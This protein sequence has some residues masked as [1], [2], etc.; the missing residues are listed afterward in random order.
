MLKI[1]D[2]IV[3]DHD[4]WLIVVAGLI[5][6]L[7]SHTC[8]SLLHRAVQQEP[9]QKMW[10]L[11][12][13][14][15]A[16][17]SGV[18]ATHFIAMLAYR[19]PML[20]G[21]DVP[22]TVLSAAVA[23]GLAAVGL[24]LALNGWYLLGGAISGGMISAMHYTGMAGFTGP[25][26]I[27]WNDGYVAASMLIGIVL[28][29]LA[30]YFLPRAAG[31]KGRVLVVSL[32][33][34]AICGMHFTGMTAAT[35]VFD[36]V[37]S[38]AETTGLERHSLAIVVAAV[39]L[40]LLGAGMASAMLDGYL[41]D[42]NALEAQRLR[43]YVGELEAT[44]SELEATTAS[45][46]RALEAAAASSQAKSQ[47]LATMS[48]ELRTPLNAI[49]GFAEILQSQALGPLGSARYT[50][51]ATDIHD[52]GSHLLSLINDVLDFSKAEAGRLDLR[53][54]LLDLR[55][56][57]G[58][59]LRLV[60]PGAREAGLTVTAELPGEAPKVLADARRLKQ[61]AL[62]LLSNALKF[63]PDGGSVRVSLSF[64]GDGAAISVADDGIGM[65]PQQIPIA[66]EPFGQVDSS[67]SRRHEG[68]G[69]GL[70]LCRRFA[71]AHGGSLSIES[72]LG[73][74][75][76]VTVRLPAG[77]LQMTEAA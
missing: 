7:A 61:I 41:A 20:A 40:L 31:M 74:G 18:W 42:R 19:T 67:L 47:F 10:W 76:V 11:G 64:D 30:F 54:E 35:L 17:G 25:F 77:R 62:N 45:L 38:L 53:E 14:A 59:C 5:C 55:E 57:V 15:V 22:L 36:P 69:L 23:I 52:S 4:V 28:A 46:S 33:T 39:A 1:A 2:C 48:H 70:P 75:T 32:F 29:V 16:M 72:V 37:G 51:Y 44:R 27:S 71:E 43:R 8:F 66:L 73:E 3:E 24:W 26:W 65:T 12:A 9:K 58:D 68:T 13:A 21:Y 63:T 6:T 34:L 56:V 60:A 50:E 49:I